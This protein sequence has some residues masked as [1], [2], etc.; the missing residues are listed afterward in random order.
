LT[1]Q[2]Q[3]KQQLWRSCGADALKFALIRAAN[4][5]KP[6]SRRTFP[7]RRLRGSSLNASCWCRRC[8]QSGDQPQDVL[9]RRFAQSAAAGDEPKGW[10]AASLGRGID[11]RVW[12]NRGEVILRLDVTDDVPPGVVAGEK[13]AWLSTSRT[14]QAISALVSTDLRAD[15]AEGACF[16]DPGRGKRH[17]I[18]EAAECTRRSSRSTARWCRCRMPRLRRQPFP[19]SG[20]G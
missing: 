4:A 11:V 16:H 9:P 5:V 6:S 14:G 7:V 8:A 10:R 13:S 3:T 17:L 18:G 19:R 20:V 1:R 15:L 2:Q 12:N